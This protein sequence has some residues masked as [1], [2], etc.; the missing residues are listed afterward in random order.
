V[1]KRLLAALVLV[2]AALPAWAADETSGDFLGLP[3]LFWKVGN[4]IVFF[5]LLVY[6]LVRPLSRFFRART[7]QITSHMKEAAHQQQEAARLR[8]EMETR[9]AALG[10]ITALRRLR[11]R[12]A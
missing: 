2:C 6:L 3:P 9:V 11:R 4:L 8:S 12:R 10:E 1:T 7:E 5:G